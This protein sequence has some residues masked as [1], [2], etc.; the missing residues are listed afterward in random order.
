[1]IRPTTRYRAVLF[2]L[3]GTLVDPRTAISGGIA[4]ALTA[5]GLPVP[6]GEALDAMI[7][8]PLA[9]SL[10]GVP[11][12]TE[13]LLPSVVDHYRSGYRSKGMAASV[14]Y[15]GIFDLLDA[16]GDAGV[17]RAVATS[18]PEPIARELL[19]I[20]GLT[21]Y[22]E[23]IC[24]ANPDES[25]PHE[26]KAAIV[27]AA[28]LALQASI[29]TGGVLDAAMVGDRFFDVDGARANGVPCVGVSWGYARD[30]EL[31]TAGA[32]AV[33]HDADDL[34]RVLDELTTDETKEA[35]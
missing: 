16:L 22:F 24:G 29:P 20:Q 27:S 2:D 21:G 1:M 10:R 28:L 30:G 34:R 25:A 6:V 14:V 8:P 5:H 35:H 12:M 3:D 11:G 15:P 33:V 4:A 23:A 19:Q 32:V 26:G 13:E 18:K 17:L 7:G 31:E 9:A